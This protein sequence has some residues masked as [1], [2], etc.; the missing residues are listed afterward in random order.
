MH[1]CDKCLKADT[2]KWHPCFSRESN[3]WCG[4]VILIHSNPLAVKSSQRIDA[5]LVLCQTCASDLVIRQPH[6]LICTAGNALLLFVGDIGRNLLKDSD[7]L[8]QKFNSSFITKFAYLDRIFNSSKAQS[9]P[10]RRK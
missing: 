10:A 7:F 3:I 9:V 2:P 4:H 1:V 6:C 8:K 5:S